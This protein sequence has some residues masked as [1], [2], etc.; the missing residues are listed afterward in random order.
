VVDL[1]GKD[2][3]KAD[4]A[5]INEQLSEFEPQALKYF[6]GPKT[7]ASCKSVVLFINKSDLLA[8]TPTQVE[9]EAKKLYAPLINSLLKYSNQIDVRVFVGSASYGHSTH[10]LF[11]HFVERILPK[12]A[13]DGQL[14]QWMKRDFAAT[15]VPSQAQPQLPP[16][17]PQPP[18]QLQ[19]QP[20]MPLPQYQTQ[21]MPP[22]VAKPSSQPPPVPGRPLT[23]QPLA[24]LKNTTPILPRAAGSQPSARKVG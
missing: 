22:L 17:Q 14:L 16:A 23:D 4:K 12:S 20:P 24:H 15:Q 5:R 6:F 3:D 7:V 8:G 1:A 19:L 18:A 13:Y 11:S 10:M 21:P 9:E 2:G